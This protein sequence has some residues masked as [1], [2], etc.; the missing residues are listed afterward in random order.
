MQMQHITIHN[1]SA[2]KVAAITDNNPIIT[3]KY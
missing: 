2:Q 1:K 3:T